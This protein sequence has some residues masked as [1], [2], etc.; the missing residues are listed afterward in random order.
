MKDNTEMPNRNI[1][2]SSNLLETNVKLSYSWTSS[3]YVQLTL[4]VSVNKT[5][6]KILCKKI[7]A[8]FSS[9]HTQHVTKNVWEYRRIFL[10]LKLITRIVT[11]MI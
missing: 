10:E 3:S 2:S 4:P 6:Q 8:V 9:I 5:K 7:N 11:I 1:T